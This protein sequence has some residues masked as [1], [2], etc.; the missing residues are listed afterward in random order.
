M[1]CVAVGDLDTMLKLADMLDEKR[2]MQGLPSGN[3]TWHGRELP[4]SMAHWSP[5]AQC[6]GAKCT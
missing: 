2:R 1:Q 6:A 3:N 5:G 4:C